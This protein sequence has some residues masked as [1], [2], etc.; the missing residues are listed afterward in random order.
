MGNDVNVL[1][2]Y[3]YDRRGLLTGIVNANGAETLFE[4]NGVGKLIKEIDPLHQVWEYA[5]DGNRNRISRKDAK[6][7]LTEYS[8]YPDDMLEQISYA[9][10]ST[11]AYQ[12]DANNNRIG[13][14]DTLGQTSW[15]FD[16]LNRV[17]EQNDPFD[18]V[19]GYQYDAASNR[20]GI[21]YPDG[22]QVGYAYSPN[23][24]LK[25]MTVN[26]VGTRH[27]VSLQTEYYRDMVGNLTQ[28]V[29]P[30]QTE[31]TVA[32]DKV[33][34]TLERINRQVT[35]G[36]KT[37][38]GFKYSYNE[39]GHISEAIKEY[40]WRKPS[41]V[42]E[43]YEYDGLHRLAYMN[44]SP[45]KNNGGVVETAYNYDPVGN[46][47]SWESNDDL[48]TNTPF[49]GFYR[50]Y[51]YN[52]ANQMLAMENAADK[53]KDDYA[54]EYSFDA[55]GNRINRQLIDR[56]GPQYGV[57]YSYDPEN[58]L[59]LAQ[60]YQIVGGSKKQAAHRI[61]RAFTTLEYDGGGRRLVQHYDPKQG[62]NG[63]DKRDEYVFDGLDPVAEYNMLNGQRTDYYRGAGNHLALMHQ[64][65]GG[66]Q[67]QMYWYHYN[68]KGD[69]VG[70]TKHNGNS[71]HN[72]RY[73]PYGA[74]LPENG[75]FTD[76]HNHYTLT[77]KEF[78]ENT[79][80]VWFG[81]RHYEP[82]T[83]VWMGQDS[84]RGRLSSPGSLHRF[85]YVGNNPLSYWDF[86]GFA[87]IKNLLKR[88]ELGE[89]SDDI[90]SQLRDIEETISSLQNN[91]PSRFRIF[92]YYDW[93]DDMDD[94]IK[95]QSNLLGEL[96]SISSELL[97]VN[98]GIESDYSYLL[99]AHNTALK[100]TKRGNGEGTECPNEDEALEHIKR[101]VEKSVLESNI[102][103]ENYL[104]YIL[105]TAQWE[106]NMGM[107]K[108]LVENSDGK[109]YA[110]NTELGKKLGNIYPGDGKKY[111]GR[112]Y[113]HLTGRSHYTSFSTD[114]LDLVNH[115]ELAEGLDLAADILID[116]MLNGRFTQY[117]L[118]DC[119]RGEK[120]NF[121]DA[122]W[123]VNGQDSAES[124][125]GVAKL[126]Y[127]AIIKE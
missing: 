83:G 4:H 1:T 73:D 18:R 102:D 21:T 120:F 125:A 41:V 62:G 9:D 126:Y 65:K 27:A 25:T 22:N 55:N 16:P 100:E 67:G 103:N 48:Q 60:D 84:Y 95:K 46:R 8:F 98:K 57:D 101:I 76:P 35:N 14:S 118:S 3:S 111:I 124:I 92:A 69:V 106:S 31:T 72:Y 121:V 30:N 104:A 116:G 108:D 94:N 28:I 45:I 99:A 112:G 56:N 26:P 2:A 68:N 71:H 58:R 54:Y 89:K 79:G 59:V 78:D 19:L 36:G 77:G 96:N 109:K 81:S 122:R 90:I 6:G 66:T 91:E 40:G 32:Y 113:A 80:L 110:Y 44:M 38:S 86:Y 75:N 17:T 23:N 33:Y 24:W 37:N 74:V 29:N 117:K 115:P 51:E 34:R 42:T 43:A 123:V 88:K 97:T 63:V 85:G 105:A 52:A 7:D 13:M 20:T 64:Y 127:N 61:D 70:L 49:D 53:K 82:E 50:S 47:L 107:E 12:Y 114:D 93:I 39:V 11:V 5:Y 15:A 10:A 119:Y 87:I